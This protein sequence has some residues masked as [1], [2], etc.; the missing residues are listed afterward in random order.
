MQAFFEAYGWWAAG[1]ALLAAEV[2]VPGIFLMWFGLAALLTGVVD[3]LFPGMGWQAQAFGFAAFSVALVFGVRPLIGRRLDEETDRPF[4]NRRLQ[5]L[6][7]ET[8]ELTRA[9]KNG[10]GEVK[11]GDTLWRVA[12]PDLPKG[13]RVRITGVREDTGELLI[14]PARDRDS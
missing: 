7:G 11:I 2:V 4:L 6:V 5:S 14:E 9:M 13:T 10:H 1:L 8:A 3:W 12:G